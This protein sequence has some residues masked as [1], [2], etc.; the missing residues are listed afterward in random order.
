MM[1]LPQC[2]AL[3]AMLNAALLL[4]HV[5]QP[6]EQQQHRLADGS[7]SHVILLHW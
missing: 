3:H 6:Q 5:L 7:I 1:L 2:H 4:Q